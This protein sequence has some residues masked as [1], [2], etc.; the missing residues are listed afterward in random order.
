MFLL[1]RFFLD[2]DDLQELFHQQPEL[3]QVTWQE[4][5]EE[6]LECGGARVHELA[7]CAVPIDHLAFHEVICVCTRSSMRTVSLVW[8]CAP[9]TETW[10]QKH[11]DNSLEG[12]VANGVFQ[13]VFHSP[14]GWAFARTHA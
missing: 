10:I 7:M 14:T 1:L 12:T 4:G 6:G 2:S 9:K 3:C 5:V 11:G 13:H 8:G